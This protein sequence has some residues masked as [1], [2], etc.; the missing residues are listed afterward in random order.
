[1][2]MSECRRITAP[3]AGPFAVV[4]VLTVV[5]A[6]G[7]TAADLVQPQEQVR[8]DIRLRRLTETVWLHT[9]EKEITGWG[10][11]SSN[12]LIVH[13]DDQ[14]WLIDTA[15]TDAATAEIA[16]WVISTF[17]Q[18]LTGAVFTHAHEDKMGGVDALRTRGIATW[19]HPRSNVLAPTRGLVPAAADLALDADG[20]AR[21]PPAGGDGIAGRPQASVLP[22][23]LSVFYPGPAH[24]EDNLVVGVEGAGVLFGGCMVRAAFSR[25]LGNLADADVARWA[26]SVAAV[27]A[28]FPRAQIVV[29]SHGPPG[30]R[31][32]LA[33]THRLAASAA[34]G[35]GQE[36]GT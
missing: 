3:H 18:P 21:A 34:R 2:R 22:P 24:T 32:L 10:K 31:E 33:L 9:S 6:T 1:M 23:G 35:A 20:E 36:S 29:P 28:R 8:G 15:W 25:S 30:G 17:G 13:L 14:V 12:G 19:A 26:G 5:F 27:E 7:A 16:D 4:M 11:V